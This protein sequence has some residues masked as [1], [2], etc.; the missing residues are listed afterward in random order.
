MLERVQEVPITSNVVVMAKNW[1]ISTH[2]FFFWEKSYRDSDTLLLSGKTH[3]SNERRGFSKNG[4][5]AEER[6]TQ[7]NS[8]IVFSIKK[9][10]NNNCI[11]LE[12][13][14][15]FTKDFLLW[16]FADNLNQNVALKVEIPK[17]S[18]RFVLQD[19]SGYRKS[20]LAWIFG[21][22]GGGGRWGGG[23]HK[24]LYQSIYEVIRNGRHSIFTCFHVYFLHLCQ[25]L[26]SKYQILLTSNRSIDFYES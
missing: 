12:A 19:V 15:Y 18:K 8:F 17:G 9:A 22:I 7:A 3:S 14:K 10:Q 25:C 16:Y 11:N 1:K 23:G 13:T 2:L 26:K 20:P 21:G 6:Y 4:V 24:S 5:E